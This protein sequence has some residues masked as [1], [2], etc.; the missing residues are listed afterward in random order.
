MCMESKEFFC[1]KHFFFYTLK[2]LTFEWT[3]SIG[4]N[5]RLGAN[6]SSKS[7]L[8]W[9][10]LIVFCPLLLTPLINQPV[11][12]V[13]ITVGVFKCRWQWSKAKRLTSPCSRM[14]SN[15]L[16]GLILIFTVDSVSSLCPPP[17]INIPLLCALSLAVGCT[18][19][20]ENVSLFCMNELCAIIMGATSFFL[21][22]HCTHRYQIV[23][24]TLGRAV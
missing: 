24:L 9:S 11:I 3:A 1:R 17:T 23:P 7:L 4:V 12:L 10:C 14:H 8:K 20:V 21:L 15:I 22:L 19:S 16:K 6:S 2:S 13:S 5:G 18:L